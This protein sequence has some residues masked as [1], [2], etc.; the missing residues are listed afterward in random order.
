MG[1]E[2]G[3]LYLNLDGL[4]PLVS[5]AENRVRVIRYFWSSKQPSAWA[6]YVSA[7]TD[8]ASGTPLPILPGLDSIYTETGGV[9]YDPSLQFGLRTGMAVPSP[10]TR[11]LVVLGVSLG[12]RRRQRS[13]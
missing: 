5:R 4:A 7:A 11:A 3:L 2:R 6:V 9:P 10:G 13:A 12:L 1:D 8:W